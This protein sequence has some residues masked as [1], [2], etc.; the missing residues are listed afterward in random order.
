MKKSIIFI[1]LVLAAFLTGCFESSPKTTV[2]K[3]Y[4]ALEKNDTQALAEVSTQETML[5]I[6][7]FGS[8]LQGMVA[9]NKVK[10]LTE[11]ID[12]ETAVVTATFEDGSTDKID[13][14]K[15]DGKWKV[16]IDMND[17]KN[18]GK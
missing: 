10:T 2:E 8:K 1:S 5:L 17:K 9:A 3:F 14:K 15:I 6:G 4:K 18:S 12:G 13:L 16:H 7:M 11:T